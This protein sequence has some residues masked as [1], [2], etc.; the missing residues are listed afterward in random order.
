ME[1]KFVLKCFHHLCLAPFL[2]GH[3][4]HWSRLNSRFHPMQ[5]YPNNKFL[6]GCSP[7]DNFP[8]EHLYIDFQAHFY[9]PFSAMKPSKR[10]SALVDRTLFRIST[11]VSSWCQIKISLISVWSGKRK[12][13]R[14]K[15]TI[16]R[17]QGKYKLATLTYNFSLAPKVDMQRL[18]IYTSDTVKNC[19]FAIQIFP[20]LIF[21]KK[22]GGH[23]ILWSAFYLIFEDISIYP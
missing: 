9:L 20:S 10:N 6:C 3:F 8:F 14:T 22:N 7:W 19:R 4:K 18:L 5:L 12:E 11:T 17:P 1:T 15:S 2:W 23:N 13:L 16:M 21:S